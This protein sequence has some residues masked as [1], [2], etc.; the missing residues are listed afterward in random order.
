MLAHP[1]YT[2]TRLHQLRDRFW[3]QVYAQRQPVDAIEASP[4]CDRIPFA[5]AQK[6]GF[7]PVKLGAPFGPVWATFWFRV[8]ATVPKEWAGS[9]VDLLWNS[10][11]EAT[12][13]VDGKTRQGLN[14]EGGHF[15]WN[16]GVRPDAMLVKQARGGEPLAFQVE[17]ACNR[18]FGGGQT[19]SYVTVSPFV[20]EQ[21]ELARFD[22]EA[23]EVANDFQCLV[24]LENEQ[25]KD[26]DK[27]WGGEL[28]SELNRFANACD[29]EDRATWAAAKP[30]L[31][32]LLSRRNG[33]TAHELSAIGHAHIDTAWLW[34][35]A[36]TWRKCMRTFSSQVLY[37]DEYP[38]HRFS[39]SQAVQFEK[40]Q[41]MNPEL[42]ARIK[43]KVTAGQFIPVGGTWVEPDCN[44]PSG[45]SLARQFLFGQRY[46]QKEF[47]IRCKEFWNP[48]V[49]GY[50]GQLPQ[51]MRQSG[52]TRFL[53]QKLSWNYFNKP[54]HHTF[55]WHG[56]DGSHVLAHFPPADTYNAN[57]SV[58]QL[59]D[60]VRN[61]KDHDRSRH[62]IM[63]FGHGDGGGGPVKHMLES[64]RRA[65]DLEGLPRTQ[66]RTSDEFFSLLEK[67]CTDRPAVVGE[68]YFELH[69]GTYTTQAAVKKGN[70]QGEIALHDAELACALALR[71]GGAAYPKAELDRLWKLLLTNQ[72]HDIL[73]GSSIGEVYV[74]AKRDH[75]EILRSAVALRDRA[76][77]ALMAHQGQSPANLAVPVNTTGF[78]RREVA[79]RPDGTLGFVEAPP[80]GVGRTV[81]ADDHVAVA[82]LPGG[83]FRLEN[84][85]L[86]ADLAA[87]GR[88]LSL[89]EKSTGREA[90]SA[91]GNVIELYDDHPTNWDA[92]DVD[93]F[94]L[95][96]G[97][98]CP[99]AESATLAEETVP[100]GSSHGR[101]GNLRASVTFTRRIGAKSRMTQRVSLAAGA[102]RIEFHAEV[103][104][105]ER[106]KFLKAAFPCDVRSMNATYEMPFGAAE[107]PTHFNTLFDIARFEVPGHRWADLSEPGFGVAL[108]TD[109]KYGY[110]CQG[111]VLR[112]SLLR[113]PSN[114]DPEADQGAHV[115][116]YALM[117]HAGDW[118]Q[119]GVVAEGL[120]FNVP[121]RWGKDGRDQ[122]WTSYASV[123]DHAGGATSLVL[124]TIKRAEDSD[125]LVVRLY[126][127]HGARGTARLKLGFPA[128]AAR[129]CDI[130][131]QPGAALAL[132]DGA[133]D[134]PFKP[135][136]VIS[137][138]ID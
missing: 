137:L 49:F 61:Y 33:T 22:A 8:A 56:I 29:P 98:P 26:L 86:R 124:D 131:E 39:C 9:R 41:E 78:A 21:C 83:G 93:P 55:D 72:F 65:K 62:S 13:W 87:D 28:L 53:T 42:Y 116:A 40:M 117:P 105:R 109:C 43:A 7:S 77:T 95:E 89:V 75:D 85:H 81:K 34:P 2:R 60:N 51:L 99:A 97:K 82:K 138:L 16:N 67:D 96:T 125:A 45:E 84:V 120:A 128:K 4:R 12:L 24:D 126:E 70:R 136:E 64:L 71:L 48:D 27:A 110:S 17:M 103:D 80:Y 59:R 30:I 38:E 90:L 1:S 133:I 19:D 127:A 32:Q 79:A 135:F 69:R 25:T 31:K 20:L 10:R 107:R 100:E 88:L 122:H 68:L 111:D 15:W 101:D 114:P 14:F 104:W 76:I 115:F 106:H 11:S 74:D 108:L 35:I 52:I 132:K 57:A 36:E 58:G 63:L 94:H 129:R 112:V 46:F 47:G 130:L 37:M 73:P 119:G 3:Q 118:R 50:N 134:L 66:V 121:L 5:D 44:I 91:P 23:W 6:L 102:R 18:M 113:A 92:W 123:A 54:L